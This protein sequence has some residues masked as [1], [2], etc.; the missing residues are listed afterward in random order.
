MLHKSWHILSV[1]LP[2]VIEYKHV[3]IHLI[4]S[5]ST[6]MDKHSLLVSSCIIPEFLYE[7]TDLP[8][9]MFHCNPFFSHAK[10][11]MS[12]T[13][14][15]TWLLLILV[16]LLIYLGNLSINLLFFSTCIVDSKC[17]LRIYHNLFTCDQLINFLVV[18]SLFLSQI[19]L[20]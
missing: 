14:F 3:S 19:I 2:Y 4:L 18:F 1:I 13:L 8:I 12:Y 6:F 15:C 16:L 11:S 5:P 9:H 17:I 10:S 20:Q 7:Y